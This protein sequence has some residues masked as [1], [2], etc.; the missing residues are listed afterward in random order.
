MKKY[1]SKLTT[2][3]IVIFVLIF[4]IVGCSQTIFVPGR[5]TWN[6]AYRDILDRQIPA[7][8]MQHEVWASTNPDSNFYLLGT[9]AGGDSAYMI[10]DNNPELY[11]GTDSMYVYA[12]S[13]RNDI[14]P[15]LYSISRSDT[16][17]GYWF[18]DARL[19]LP[20]DGVV[21]YDIAIPGN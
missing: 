11:I 15:F 3:W 2:I 10:K 17:K 9:T 21:I 12:Y 5:V 6:T 1:L 7:D 14:I 20:S 18:P 16:T 8:V 4:A 13:F 19:P